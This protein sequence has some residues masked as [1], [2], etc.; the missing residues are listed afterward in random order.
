MEEEYLQEFGQRL[1]RLINPGLPMPTVQQLILQTIRQLRA[2][3]SLP[4]ANRR[5]HDSGPPGTM[6]GHEIEI[7][8]VHDCRC[9]F[10]NSRPDVAPTGKLI[11][12]PLSSA[13]SSQV[14]RSFYLAPERCKDGHRDTLI[15]GEHLY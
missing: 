1:A 3:G 4:S 13:S 14:Y 11:R 6:M 8:F 7:V 2:S 9:A 5:L 10:L 15:S 12:K